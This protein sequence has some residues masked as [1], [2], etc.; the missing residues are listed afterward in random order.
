M[1]DMT[2]SGA[3]GA[4]PA[5]MTSLEMAELTGK[6]HDNVRRTIEA[7]VEKGVIARPQIEEVPEK[8]GNG[9]T[10]TTQ[11]YVFEGEQGKRDSYI[12][13]A[14]LSPEFTARLVDRWQELEAK[15]HVD[16]IAA[17]SDPAT[18]RALLLGYTERVLALE[19]KVQD[20]APK[21][22]FADQVTVSAGSVSI[23]QA[24]KILGTGRN[25]LMAKL[26]EWHWVTRLG[27]P[28]QEKINA[29][30]LDVK[31]GSWEHP[32]KGLQRSVTALITGKGLRKLWSL[33]FP[34]A[35]PTYSLN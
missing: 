18:M 30:L 1:N 7:L 33:F 6:R 32:E 23:A 24:A 20:D 11:V 5:R 35:D 27:E 16:P 26:R 13:V 8:G 2:F 34:D 25:R 28:Y 19:N 3:G 9:R 17:L 12:V 4:A 29:G 22:A 15:K 21:V 31:I 10:Y 14:Q